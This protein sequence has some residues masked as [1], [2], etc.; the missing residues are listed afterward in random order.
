[1]S[2]VPSW[3]A[4]SRA[5]A[6]HRRSRAAA[7]WE[8]YAHAASTARHTSTVP[9]STARPVNGR[10]AGPAPKWITPTPRWTTGAFSASSCAIQA[11]SRAVSAPTVAG[12]L[13]RAVIRPA[14]SVTTMGMPS[15]RT[16]RARSSNASVA[17]SEPGS[18]RPAN[19]RPN[20]ALV[21]RAS[22]RRCRATIQ[23]YP[24]VIPPSRSAR[25]TTTAGT[26]RRSATLRA[27]G[28]HEPLGSQIG[29]ER[30]W[31]SHG[32]VGLL[33]GLEQ[34]RDRA[35]QGDARG[36][37][38]MREL[39]FGARG[40]PV[41]DVGA[42]RLEIGERAR[43]RHL[44]PLSDTRRPHLE[45]VLL[46]GGEPEVA[47]GHEHHT[48][49]QLQ[50][51]Q[52]FLRVSRQHLVL[53]GRIFR[54]AEAH[55]LD[56]VELMH[57]QQAAGVLP[58]GT[59]FAAKAGCVRGVRERQ[60]RPVEDFV[61]MQIG[62]GHFGGRN[63]KQIV[64]RRL[65]RVFFEFRQL[66]R[67]DHAV[68]A[69]EE[70][71]LDLDV[72]VLAGVQ[73]EH[74]VDQG[75]HEPGSA[76]HEH[77]EPRA[78]ELRATREIED[79][80]RFSQLPVRSA[81]PRSRLAPRPDDPVRRLVAVGDF[82]EREVGD[83]QQLLLDGRLQATELRLERVDARGVLT[84]LL[85]HLRRQLTLRLHQARVRLRRFVP[86]R[87]KL[88][89]LP[90]ERPAPHV[91]RLELVEESR[92]GGIAAPG[93]RGAHLL[94]RGAQQLEIDHRP[95]AWAVPLRGCGIRNSG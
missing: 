2:G 74:E 7:T 34:G 91:E 87:L 33:V 53:G 58:G 9:S 48:V 64:R 90:G 1:M 63:E 73:V 78:G 28:R 46:G 24:M 13:S 14:V 41:T 42:A 38:R 51:A 45:I 86:L 30:P 71:R 47:D 27:T 61:A 83:V 95:T 5:M 31:D 54:A 15:D 84:A 56:L 59:R 55:Q 57:P 82:G 60:L 12:A 23:P 52:H 22:S 17:A 21:W 44:E 67:A 19:T 65:V 10:A 72:A 35:R 94:R 20:N 40:R 11:R 6:T 4:D 18:F 85:A 69:N 39:R 62:H 76:A 37:E 68:A 89:E 32:A 88:V 79:A 29:N 16:W 36:V 49:R 25:P 50:P 66:A 3:C 80:E 26:A 81:A 70:R 8:R 77:G 92:N 43:A 75:A 93:E